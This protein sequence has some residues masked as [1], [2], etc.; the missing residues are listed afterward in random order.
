MNLANK[1]T[2][3]RIAL[4]PVYLIL[5]LLGNCDSKQLHL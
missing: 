4:V 2:C 1:I 5:M 3:V